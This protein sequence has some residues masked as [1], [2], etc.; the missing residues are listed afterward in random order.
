MHVPK[1]K[2]KV[3]EKIYALLFLQVCRRGI[4]RAQA[5]NDR[6][7]MTDWMDITV[8]PFHFKSKNRKLT[9]QFRK[10]RNKE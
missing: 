4:K 3:F 2:K 6:V 1:L 9:L 10:K 5:T 8:F 7:R